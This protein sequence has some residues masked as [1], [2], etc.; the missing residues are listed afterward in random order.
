MTGPA[1]DYDEMTT[2][3]LGF[4]SV[5]EQRRLREGSVFVCGVGGMG[6]VAA[7][8][9]VRAGVGR[10][11]I[12]DIDTFET[13]NLNR[14]VHAD[15]ASLGRAKAEVTGER[16]RAI[17]PT[18][19]LEV[20]GKEWTSALDAILPHCPVTINS[21][22]DLAAGLHLYRRA[23]ALRST[24]IDAYVSPLPNVTVVRPTD[25]RP[26][27]RLGFGTCGTPWNALTD[28][29]RAQARTAE[30]VHVLAHSSS[31]DH[32]DADVARDVIAGRRARP[33]FA[34]VV[35]LAGTLMAFEALQ[36]LLGRPTGT[37]FR[38]CFHNPWTGR[39]ERPHGALIGA[40]RERLVRRRLARFVAER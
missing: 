8:V 17:N 10:L 26:E 19:Q 11:V 28:A 39:T 34:P 15:A 25:P 6:G 9:L 32:I 7:Q 4:V 35:W 5:A 27:D 1:F 14:Q 20:H 29:Q 23:A 38:G 16:L 12:A 30:F 13:S 24:V 40:L 36:C 18:L 3:N 22:D 21:M 2:R 31:L 37:D 33:S